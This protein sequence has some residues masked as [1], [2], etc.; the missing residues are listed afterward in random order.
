MFNVLFKN[1]D[2]TRTSVSITKL[3][4]KL[5]IGYEAGVQRFRSKIGEESNLEYVIDRW[6]KNLR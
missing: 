1:Q 4:T 5:R 6:V 2:S 3:N